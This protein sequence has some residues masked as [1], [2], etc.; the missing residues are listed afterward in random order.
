[1]GQLFKFKGELER[2]S[3][4]AKVA[5]LLLNQQFRGSF[6]AYPASSAQEMLME[7]SRRGGVAKQ[8]ERCGGGLSSL[9]H[10]K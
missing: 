10:E 8:G 1:M 3:W 6:L 5:D 4:T 2:S 7:D 9:S